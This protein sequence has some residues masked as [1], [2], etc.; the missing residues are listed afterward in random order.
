MN[1]VV[2]IDESHINDEKGTM[3]NPVHVTETEKDWHIFC[4]TFNFQRGAVSLNK[5]WV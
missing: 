5:L 4:N 2:I 1:R 3:L